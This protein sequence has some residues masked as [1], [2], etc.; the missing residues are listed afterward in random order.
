VRERSTV[1]V[2]RAPPRRIHRGRT[3]VAEQV[4][5]VLIGGELADETPREALVEK[6]TRVEVVLKIHEESAAALGD[7]AKHAA[8][9][10]LAVL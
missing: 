3:C 4:E 2:E 1:V 5:E 9:A 6:Q 10:E 8:A 7:L